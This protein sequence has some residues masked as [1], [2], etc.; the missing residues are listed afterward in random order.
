MCSQ[1]VWNGDPLVDLTPNGKRSTYSEAEARAE[2]AARLDNR[3]QE[4]EETILLRVVG[5]LGDRER[6]DPEYQAGLRRAVAAGVDYGIAALR[7]AD[8][9]VPPI[10]IDLLSQARIAAR[11]RVPIDA[12]LQRYIA[13]QSV[14]DQIVLHE[15]GMDSRL[16]KCAAFLT[17]SASLAFQALAAAAS[18]EYA[19]VQRQKPPSQ[20][21]ARLARIARLLD[22]QPARTDDL[23]YDFA[24]AHIGVIAEGHEA[25]TYVRSL[26]N[27][28]EG[29]L[30]VARPE[31]A[32]VWAWLGMRQPISRDRL[33]QTTEPLWSLDCALGLGEPGVQMAG[34]RKTHEQ[35]RI[36]FAHASQSRPKP[37]LYADVAVVH[38]ARTD[39]M[40]YSF[41]IDRYLAPLEGG[42]GDGSSLRATLRAY[43][44][45]GCNTAAAAAALGIS[46]R[47]VSNRLKTVEARVGRPIRYL[48]LEL[49][50]ALRASER[51]I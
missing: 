3:R 42:R 16:N 43:F 22:G 28:L 18:R 34:W 44:D 13:A 26:S 51:D 7:L 9:E 38:S 10:S 31:A 50:L 23:K 6:D 27:A 1:A 12:V 47:T 11:Q 49:Q 19:H 48:A 30:L 29:N 4:I 39:R 21:A 41:L 46:R 15:A 36:A 24:A 8:G 17:T 40:L 37:T 32:L 14:F 45:A 33:L 20:A 5:S 25:L 2:M 35:A